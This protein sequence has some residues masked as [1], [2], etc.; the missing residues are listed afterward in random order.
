MTYAVEARAETKKTK[1]LLRTTEMQVLRK[2]TGNRLADRIRNNDIRQQCDVPDI[3]R[4][5][6]QRKREWNQHVSRMTPERTVRIARDGKPR[7]RRPVGRPPRR[8]VESWTSTSQ[9]N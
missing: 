9:E 1:A 7:S 6:R 8:W 4:W 5:S 2:I 3:V